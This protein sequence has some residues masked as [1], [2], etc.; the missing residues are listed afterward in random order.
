VALGAVEWWTAV[1]GAVA[2]GAGREVLGAVD[3]RAAQLG[4]AGQQR[5]VVRWAAALARWCDGRGAAVL[6]GVVGEEQVGDG[7]G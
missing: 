7:L 5:L 3:R 6:G 2:A 1:L 4:G